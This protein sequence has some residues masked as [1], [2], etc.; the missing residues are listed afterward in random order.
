MR[1][2]GIFNAISGLDTYTPLNTKDGGGFHC[3]GLSYLGF[4]GLDHFFGMLIEE[5]VDSFLEVVAAEMLPQPVYEPRRC[6]EGD[7]TVSLPI[8]PNLIGGGVGQQRSYVT[9]CYAL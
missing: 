5:T 4:R 3:L 1:L 2:Q 6:H 9:Q 7:A 8:D